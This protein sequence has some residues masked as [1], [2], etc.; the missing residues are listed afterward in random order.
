MQAT[1][2][3]VDGL[4]LRVRSDGEGPAVLFVH[5]LGSAGQSWTP[6]ADL[7]ADDI[8][9][10]APDLPGFG[11]S[12]KPRRTYTPAFLAETLVSLV[13]ELGIETTHVVGTSLGGQVALELALRRP[14]RVGRVVAVAP[15]GIPPTSFEGTT[16]L[17]EYA[18]LLDARTV[19]E[20]QA[21]RAATGSAERADEAHRRS[22]EEVLAYVTSPGAR[23]AFE[24]ALRESA[25]A[26]RLG[27]LLAEID[28][29][30]L[31]VWGGQDPLI[32]LDVCAPELRR[33]PELELAVFP[34]AGH[35]PHAEHPRAFTELLLAFLEDRLASVEVAP[36]RIRRPDDVSPSTARS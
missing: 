20:V 28:P 22:P 27:P 10:I 36:C 12:E 30:P 15:A 7:A 32:P 3:E 8:H 34:D 21:A 13:D 9:A 25:K 5:G 17:S 6:V 33:T 16:A 29:L 35:S 18:Q 24:S 14:D 11:R 31:V 19:E 23:E 2:V 1:T 26:R 4:E